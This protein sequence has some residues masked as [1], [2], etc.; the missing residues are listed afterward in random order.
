MSPDP[1]ASVTG[2]EV[3]STD[4]RWKTLFLHLRD[5]APVSAW[6]S[7]GRELSWASK[8]ILHC[9]PLLT[10]APSCRTPTPH[11]SIPGVSL[12]WFSYSFHIHLSQ[13][14]LFSFSVLSL[15]LIL[16]IPFLCLHKSRTHLSLAAVDTLN[17]LSFVDSVLQPNLI[18]EN[19]KTENYEQLRIM[20]FPQLFIFC[21]K[22]F[23]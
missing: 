5:M 16:S 20:N 22:I 21:S 9:L 10:S 6:M 13:T 11:A 18:I 3:I 17:R 2:G 15:A 14:L 7:L 23:R 8:S 12:A 1:R 4:S 19:Y